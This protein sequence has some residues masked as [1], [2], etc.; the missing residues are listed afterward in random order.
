[1]REII[2]GIV[3]DAIVHRGK[4]GFEPPIKKWLT[5][6]KEYEEELRKGVE[7]FKSL[8]PQI[9]TFFK[10]KV[11][12]ENNSIYKGYKIRLYIFNNWLNHNKI[13]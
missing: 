7:A 10:N 4:Q 13:I 11:F 6:T 12:C 2:K 9:Y 3:P 1:M 8:H 5:E